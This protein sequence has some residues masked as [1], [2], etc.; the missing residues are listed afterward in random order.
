MESR[1][2]HSVVRAPPFPPKPLFYCF[3]RKVGHGRSWSFPSGCRHPKFTRTDTTAA[4]PVQRGENVGH[5]A[6]I[7]PALVL[8]LD[9]ESFR[10][11]FSDGHS[12]PLGLAG[13]VSSDR[14]FPCVDHVSGSLF[15]GRC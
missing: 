11:D 15:G 6:L 9:S 5:T 3:V 14:F 4:N 2:R 12:V 7:N 8:H 10:K 1:G 13:Q